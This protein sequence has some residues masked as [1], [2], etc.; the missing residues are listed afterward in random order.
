[1]AA[2][3]RA[4]LRRRFG[5]AIVSIPDATQLNDNKRRGAMKHEVDDYRETLHNLASLLLA[6]KTIRKRR[7][8]STGQVL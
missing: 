4:R 1:M 7:Q 8:G 3:Q 6:N 2:P 5:F